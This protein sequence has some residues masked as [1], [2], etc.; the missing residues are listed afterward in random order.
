MLEKKN[1][2]AFV[3]VRAEGVVISVRAHPRSSRLGCLGVY[4]SEG[5]ELKW[6]V[7][8]A[9]VDG[10]ANEELETS[11]ARFFDLPRS[12][13][14]VVRGKNSRCKGLL[15]QGLEPGQI[16]SKLCG[17]LDSLSEHKKSK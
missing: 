7:S 15:L 12:Q 16:E 10:K 13:V 14:S 17:L 3:C 2:F 8:S 5:K 9:P 1:S 11:V 4:G 6:G